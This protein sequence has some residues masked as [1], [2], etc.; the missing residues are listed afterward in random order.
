MEITDK[1]VSNIAHLARL[2]LEDQDLEQHK[3]KLNDILEWIEQLQKVDTKGVEPLYH[4][5]DKATQ[6][7]REDTIS[8]ENN[9]EDLLKI[10]ENNK[11]GFYLVPKVIE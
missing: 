11:A 1:T 7:V 4:P 9:R 10:S 5:L 6:P 3:N 8:E 2:H